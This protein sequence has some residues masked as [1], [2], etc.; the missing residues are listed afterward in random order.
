[1][2]IRKGNVKKIEVQIEVF[3]ALFNELKIINKKYDQIQVSLNSINGKQ[4]E[5]EEKFTSMICKLR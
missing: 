2:K 5:L 4:I 1:M 3:E